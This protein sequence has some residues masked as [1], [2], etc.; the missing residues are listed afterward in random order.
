MTLSGFPCKNEDYRLVLITEKP[1]LGGSC[2]ICNHVN[3]GMLSMPSC[4]D[5]SSST[6]RAMAQAIALGGIVL[7]SVFHFHEVG[8]IFR[9]RELRHTYAALL[10]E[11]GYTIVAVAERLGDTVEVA[12]TTYSH[13]CPDKKQ[14]MADDLDRRAK[15][16]PPAAPAASTL[17]TTCQNGLNRPKKKPFKA[18]GTFPVRL[19]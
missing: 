16:E 5:C 18:N 9:F 19:Q 3:I 10:V 15:G 14:G 8:L 7:C 6:E 17:W 1:C 12:L 13:L 2:A 11:L 4:H